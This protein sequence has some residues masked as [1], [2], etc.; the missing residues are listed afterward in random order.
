MF[1]N[2]F[3]LKKIVFE[4]R[5]KKKH[6]SCIS[7]IKNMFGQFKKKKILK[8]K[9]EN[10]FGDFED[11]ETRLYTFYKKQM[12]IIIQICKVARRVITNLQ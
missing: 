2:S 3:F 11:A 1:S 8:K 6:F 9:I 7:K 10:L 5:K 4:N 12:K